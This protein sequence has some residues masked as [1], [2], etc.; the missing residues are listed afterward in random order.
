MN[1]AELMRMQFQALLDRVAQTVQH[2]SDADMDWQPRLQ[3]DAIQ[4]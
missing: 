2:V 1:A 3:P 4:F